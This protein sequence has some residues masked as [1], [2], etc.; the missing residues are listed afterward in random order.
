MKASIKWRVA[1]I[2]IQTCPWMSHGCEIVMAMR[3]LRTP[4][5]TSPASC[6][7][8]YCATIILT[9]TIN[10]VCEIRGKGNDC[11]LW[12]IGPRPHFIVVKRKYIWGN[13][14]RTYIPYIVCIQGKKDTV[15]SMMANNHILISLHL[16]H[17]LH[18]HESYQSKKLRFSWP[19]MTPE[20]RT[21]KT[22]PS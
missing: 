22:M 11:S 19:L 3:F 5:L 7:F 17:F 15:V 9:V 21:T 4:L 14:T 16:R 2:F 20:G 13:A 8:C 1:Y 12:A 10:A 6:S 18:D